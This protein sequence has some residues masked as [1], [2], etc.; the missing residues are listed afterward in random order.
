MSG[1]DLLQTTLPTR[2]WQRA[3]ARV[4]RR[5]VG[6]AL[7]WLGLFL[8]GPQAVAWAAPPTL[9][10]P[11][12]PSNNTTPAFSG[13]TSSPIN[14]LWEPFNPVIVKIYATVEGKEGPEVQELP[15]TPPFLGNDWTAGPAQVLAPGTYAARAEQAGEASAPVSFTIDT[16]PPVV[17][18]TS[19]ANGSSAIGSSQLV[20]GS[21]GTA[22][23]DL[24]E[25][26]VQLSAGQG[27]AFPLRTVTVTASGGRWEGPFAGLAPG[28][29]TVRS[30]QRDAAGNVGFSEP[31]TFS[32]R[33]PP[34]PPVPQPPRASFVWFPSSPVVGETVTLLS[35]STDPSSA[36]TAF[37]WAPSGNGSFRAG[38]PLITTSFSAPGG[39]VVRLRVSDANGLSSVAAETIPV[40]PAA[41]TLM[42]PF[43]IVR[44]SGSETSNGVRLT[45]LTVQAPPGARVTVSCQGRGCP[46][47]SESRVAVSRVR[48]G[49]AGTVRIT[50]RRFER[51]LRAGVILRIRVFKPGEIGKYTRFI[52]RRGLLP[53]RLDTC[54]DSGGF[55]PM[56]CPSS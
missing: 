19:P 36:I 32:L 56:A 37:A 35:S 34:P 49:A 52:V 39:H 27:T 38:K 18:I 33:S 50:F 41:L 15:P 20:S 28:T 11:Q 29:Y 13:T 7:L 51:I 21:A 22:E 43:P 8:A 40:A 6:P 5:A 44:I 4:T 42:Q 24:A 17:T 10:Q 1:D 3:Q 45:T 14:E 54:L 25:V 9:N 23:G 2:G 48:H 47:R 12:S 30:E 46:A 55:K 53:E 26:T 16:T 31:V